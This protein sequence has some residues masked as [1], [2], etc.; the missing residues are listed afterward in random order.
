M[1]RAFPLVLFA[2]SACGDSETSPTDGGSDAPSPLDAAVDASPKDAT[3]DTS[4]APDASTPKPLFVLVG[5]GDGKIRVFSV[6]EPSGALT[7]MGTASPG[8]SP[9]FLAMDP[10]TKKVYAVDEANDQ[11]RAFTFD[12]KAGSLTDLG[13][14]VASGGGGPT[15]V[16]IDATGKLVLVANYGGGTASVFP[17][18]GTGALGPASDTKA[19]GKN[20]H[21]AITSPSGGWAFVPCLGSNLIAQYKLDAN[22]KLTANGTVSPPANAGPRHLAFRPD[23]KFAYG[24]NEL[25]STVTTYAYDGT[26]GKLTAQATLSSLPA[27]YAGQNTGAEIVV[28]PSGAFVYGSNR[29]HDSIVA[30]ASDKNTGALSLVGHVSTG[31]KT[32]RSFALDP[33][34][35]LLFAA[36]QASGTVAAFT[37]GSNG[38]PVASGSPVAIPSP[39]FVGAWRVP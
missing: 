35:K 24:I 31:G 17:I 7:P 13:T 11:V 30:F 12:P 19:P 6:A 20:A 38:L 4:P 18:L 10:A 21:L 15:H 37:I 9:S 34:A 25:A 1:R 36:N 26:S 5:S 22:E 32:P 2:L 3:A 23:E 39:T 14:P 29:G 28:H 27:N 33:D 16:S 8:G